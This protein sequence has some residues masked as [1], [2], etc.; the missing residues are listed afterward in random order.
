[1]AEAR[2]GW[3][4]SSP[5]AAL[6]FLPPDVLDP[7]AGMGPNVLVVRAPYDLTLTVSAAGP[8]RFVRVPE[9]GGLSETG[10]R[11]LVTPILPQAQRDPGVPAV[12]VAL[13]LVLVTDAEAVLT[14]I[15]PCLDPGFRTWP[16]TLVSGR[17]ALRAWPR[18]LNA[19]LE[20]QDRSSPWV[21]RRGDA[22]CYLVLTFPDPDTRLVLVQAASTPALDRHLAQVDNVSAFARNVGPMFAEAAARRPA[23]LLTPARTG[24]PDFS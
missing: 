23:R 24:C 15:P 16:G 9:P 21:L 19:V 20:W 4:P 10:F 12:Q 3:R 14:L 7:G 11:G 2:V 5:Q 13:N 17:F 22:L 8:A 6:A 1:M 18:S